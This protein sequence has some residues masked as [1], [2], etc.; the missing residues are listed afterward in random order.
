MSID[1]KLSKV[2]ISEIIQSGEFFGYGLGSLGKKALTNI[3]TH[4]AR[5]N[6]PG[7][8]S[9][10]TLDVINKSERKINEK[11]SVRAGKRFTLSFFEWIYEWYYNH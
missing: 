2:Q 7:L 8:V 5:D 9:N 6:L 11:G 4:L 3:A 10:L 1:I